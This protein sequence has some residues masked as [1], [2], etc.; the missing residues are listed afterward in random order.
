MLSLLYGPT[1]TLIHDYWKDHSFDC[2]D[3]CQQSDVS[4]FNTLSKFVMGLPMWL[5]SKES[6]CEAEDAGGP[7]FSLWVGNEGMA[8]HSSI[9]A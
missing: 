3:L 5:S 9:L 2:M 1:L 6:T 8:I 4:V 7:R